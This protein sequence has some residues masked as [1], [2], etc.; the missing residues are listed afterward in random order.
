MEFDQAGSTNSFGDDQ[1]QADIHADEVIFKHLRS[2]P[3][4]ASASSEEQSDILPMAQQQQ[5]GQGYSVAFDPLD[6]SSIFD[7]NFAVGS[8][9]G[10]WPGGTPLGQSG[11]DQVAAA[12]A[13]Y[14]FR[15]LLVMAIPSGTSRAA[16]AAAA[17]ASGCQQQQQ[18]QCSAAQQQQQQQD[19]QQQQQQQ[20]QGSVS[21]AFQVLEFVLTDK[22]W[23]LRRLHTRLGDKNNVAPANIRAAAGNEAY[24]QL[25]HAWIKNGCKLRYS[26][27]MVPDVHHMLAKGGGV[28][29]NPKS[30]TAPAKLRLLYECAPVALVVEAAGGVS[31]DGQG[32]ILDLVINDTGA[33]SIIALGS[34]PQV[35]QCLDAMRGA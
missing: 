22:R 21:E 4:V 20:Q 6:G 35:Q 11:R 1:L 33:R 10:V 7:A 32:S 23:R 31:H 18:Q 26:G 24:H 27:G 17:A 14:G 28:F 8:I 9:F 16:A 3:A 30:A 13:V 2:C 15:T 5:P 12:Y 34:A 29:C 25:L 19:G